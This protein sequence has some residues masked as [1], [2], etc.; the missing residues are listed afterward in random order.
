MISA[1][2]NVDSL[3]EI[4]FEHP[5]DTV[6]LMAL[7]ALT[8]VY[9]RDSAGIRYSLL[10]FE[11]A[12]QVGNVMHQRMALTSAASVAWN[13]RDYP[14]ALD[15]RM[16]FLE[17]EKKLN[18]SPEN[19]AG[20][21]NAVGV[22]YGRVGRKDSARACIMRALKLHKQANYQEGIA[23][24][25]VNLGSSFVDGDEY[26]RGIDTMLQA[27]NYEL[28]PRME[29][30]VLA[31]LAWAYSI[32]DQHEKTLE[33]GLRATELAKKIRQ[34]PN[35]TFWDRL[36]LARTKSIVAGAYISLDSI[37]KAKEYQ[38]ES[39]AIQDSMKTDYLKG[40][41]YS[42]MGAI[43]DKEGRTADAI[44]YYEIALPHKEKQ[45]MFQ[46]GLK[47]SRKLAELYET[48]GD[49]KN[50]NRWHSKALAFQDTIVA[51]DLQNQLVEYEFSKSLEESNRKREMELLRAEI[52]HESQLGKQKMFTWIGAG[53]GLVI[54]L[55]LILMI[56]GYRAK[57]RSAE[58]LSAKNELIQTQKL[59]VEHKNQ[60]ILDSIVYAQRIQRAILPP[61]EALNDTLGDGFILYKPKDIVAG[62]F[63]WM[64]T[65]GDVTL[66]AAA[67]CTGHGVPGAM[68]SVM[69]SNALS[70]AVKEDG[71]TSPS[72]ILDQAVVHLEQ[73]FE[74]SKETVSDGMDIA[75][76]AI[77][78][79][80]L[81]YA[82]ANNPLWIVRG[83][84][85]LETKPDKQPVGKF[86]HRQ[87]F[88]NHEIS[89]EKGDTIYIFSDGFADQFGG[90]K[91][92]KFKSRPFK[93]LLISIQGE[94][95]DA[96]KKLLDES[97]EMWRGAMDQIDDVCILGVRI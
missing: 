58:V 74:K 39:I 33:A 34:K 3:K 2:Q 16:R 84:E 42:M 44:R 4:A 70:K 43:A 72:Q 97:F 90:P 11:L 22:V 91:G 24:A 13:I 32:V 20:A 60:E 69:C 47:I 92:K 62:D 55:V 25:Y 9:E 26:Q 80:T 21:I 95:M 87:P 96:Q 71:N 41:S 93:D 37:E 88:T 94:S 8:D 14:T 61:D 51:T 85:V 65:V 27:F 6:R 75:L 48:Q 73:R 1:G 79:S 63:Y 10:Q 12:E 46:D 35:V 52:E 30:S 82:G 19:I 53:I 54:L 66:F 86:E 68:V 49:Y 81:Q 78:G 76:C 29:L 56:R 31:R 28:S 7:D 36:Q 89:L 50:A 83:G 23:Q 40:S 17:L 38:L 45:N 67:D 15:Y 18:E 77:K 59:Q 57:K 64:E 5:I